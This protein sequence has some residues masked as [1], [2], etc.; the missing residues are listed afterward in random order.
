MTNLIINFLL[1]GL[2]LFEKEIKII[3]VG[4][5]MIGTNYPSEKYLPLND[6]KDIFKDVSQIIRE[7]DLSFGNPRG[8]YFIW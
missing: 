6:G 5:M 1:I 3:G 8:Y 7:A 4:D 2:N